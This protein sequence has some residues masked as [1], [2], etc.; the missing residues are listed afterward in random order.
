MK[1]F[2][3][4]ISIL[5]RFAVAIRN[6]LYDKGYIKQKEISTVVISVGNLSTG[7]TGK[8][9]LVEFIAQ[10][11][12]GQN[13]FVAV[14]TKGYKRE[15]D[16]ICVAEF[17]FKNENNELSSEKFGDEGLML[18][19]NL[20]TTN[21]G[22]GI[23]VVSDDKTSGAKFAYKKFKPDVILIDDGYQHRKLTRNFDILIIDPKQDERLLPAGR[24]REPY[25]SINRADIVAVNHKFDEEENVLAKLYMKPAIYCRYRLNGI[26]DFKGN[27][28][29]KRT[30][31][32][33]AFCGIAIPGSFKSMLEK[34][35]FKI[36]RL[37]SFSDHHYYNSEN[38]KNIINA[39]KSSG[40]DFILTTQKDFVRLK[41]SE[42]NMNRD[43]VRNNPVYY[44]EIK[45]E[46]T[47]NKNILTERI[48]KL[49]A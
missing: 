11:I 4:P 31:N 33:T 26:Y 36:S 7:G 40:S 47:Q 28:I 30:G 5:F 27:K 29:D 19:E 32:V 15:D 22:R 39:F 13:K 20:R 14:V 1:Y 48:D 16:D 35:N 34:N 8:T 37:I 6:L 49:I 38:L 43:F 9:P 2:L 25:S 44:A 3:K 10:Y 17:G 21:S 46:I 12:T 23:L 18:L 24:M 45:L 41:Y 42:V